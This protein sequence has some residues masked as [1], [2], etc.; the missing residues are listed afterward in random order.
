MINVPHGLR[1][2]NTQSPGSSAV[3]FKEVIETW[4]LEPPWV[5]ALRTYS[6][7]LFPA[8]SLFSVYAQHGITQLPARVMCHH[9][10]PTRVPLFRT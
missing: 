10:T 4:G 5:G 3:L 2:L 7:A 6:C 9:A 8:C 1:Y